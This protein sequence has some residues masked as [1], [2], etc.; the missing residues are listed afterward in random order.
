MHFCSK[1]DNMYYIKLTSADANTLIYYC[2]NCGHEDSTITTDNVCVLNTMITNKTQK[3]IF[4]I[5][6]YTKLDPTL[7]RVSNIKCPSLICT[8][9]T[10]QT[11]KDIIYIRYDNDNMDYV[12]L[13]TTCDSI[14]T[15]K[16]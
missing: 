11:P 5:N 1:C 13:C 7:P 6:K 8:T 3:Y 10:E 15:L 12:Y 2:K 16:E 4:N 14:W 9:N